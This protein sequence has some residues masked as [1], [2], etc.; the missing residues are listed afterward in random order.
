MIESALGYD[1]TVA[2]ASGAELTPA[3]R[4]LT[5]TGADVTITGS[6]PIVLRF[7][8]KGSALRWIY[9]GSN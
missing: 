8:Y 1:V 3:N 5:R 2:N 9:D 6:G 4:I 7:H